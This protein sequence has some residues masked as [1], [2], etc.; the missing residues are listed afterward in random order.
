M[1]AVKNGSQEANTT[2]SGSSAVPGS[3]SNSSLARM[4]DQLSLSSSSSG[5]NQEPHP[6]L[7]IKG[8]EQ[9]D[10]LSKKP[11]SSVDQQ[12]EQDL[13]SASF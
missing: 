8:L 9:S 7:R 3:T 11:L 13:G 6:A 10:Q 12:L 4:V 1:V 2:K 5:G